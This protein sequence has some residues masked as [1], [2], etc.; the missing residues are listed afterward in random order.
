MYGGKLFGVAVGLVDGDEHLVHL[1]DRLV[2][3][4]LEKRTEREGETL[5]GSL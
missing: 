2:H 5:D 4:R 3:P 1:V